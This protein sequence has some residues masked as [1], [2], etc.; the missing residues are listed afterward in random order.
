MGETVK[1]CDWLD[2]SKPDYVEYHDKEWG[3]PVYDDQV[4]FEFLILE[5]A[6]AGLSWYTI[7]KRRE[8]YRKAFANFDPVK[9]AQFDAAR[10]EELMQ[11]S[12][13]IRNRAKI[14]SAIN[15]AH[16]FIDIQR[17]Y[18]SFSSFIWAY[19]ND[20]PID[21]RVEGDAVVATT[22][23]SDQLS[24][25][26]K[27][28]GFKFLGSTTLYAFLQATGIVNDHDLDCICRSQ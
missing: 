17:E 19:V 18:G 4:F 21:Q 27:K 13:I 16:L 24:K 9:V 26:L 8:G 10:V 5:S 2:T 6:Q 25:D 20:Q 22:P 1:R 28:R 11:D 3:R 15:N 7:L 12:S 23:L 14:E